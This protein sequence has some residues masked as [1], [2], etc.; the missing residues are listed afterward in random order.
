MPDYL[1]EDVPLG[2]IQKVQKISS[3]VNNE[4]LGIMIFC[5]VSSSRIIQLNS[6]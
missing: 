6:V 4:L 5:K 3:Q 1:V 2:L